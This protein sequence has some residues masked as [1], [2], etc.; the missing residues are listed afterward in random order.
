MWVYMS[1]DILILVYCL[2]HVIFSV[3]ITK[4]LDN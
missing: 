3:S 2:Y 1:I 4:S